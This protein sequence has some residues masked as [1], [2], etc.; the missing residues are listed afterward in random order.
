[1]RHFPGRGLQPRERGVAD[2]PR[3]L[4]CRVLQH[5]AGRVA[6]RAG[7]HR[8]RLLGGAQRE[9][10]RPLHHRHPRAAERGAPLQRRGARRAPPL[11]RPCRR[12]RRLRGDRVPS[13]AAL[14]FGRV[15]HAA[16]NGRR[17]PAH[18]AR[19]RGAEAHQP[20]R[21]RRGLPCGAR[22]PRAHRVPAAH[23]LFPRPHRQPHQ[24]GICGRAGAARG[25][26]LHG[27]GRL[28]RRSALLARARGGLERL[29][30]LAGQLRPRGRDGAAA[31][32]L[33]EDHDR[34]AADIG[35]CA[36]HRSRPHRRFRC[37]PRRRG[38]DH[39]R[40]RAR[41][42]QPRPQLL[43]ARA[44]SAAARRGGI[45]ALCRVLRTPPRR[46]RNSARP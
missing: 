2:R 41:H 23:R 18:A 3:S 46:S 24:Q 20:G 29:R 27:R 14:E 11:S 6:H 42:H 8:R 21:V 7:H 31:P 32:A 1:M 37:E 43:R 17:D 9:R 34:R 28:P 16:G 35:L 10:R 12:E 30:L 19:G 25:A 36:R 5:R 4:Q 38:D 44:R 45:R 40:G 39:A 13:H 26:R 15:V 33:A 22:R